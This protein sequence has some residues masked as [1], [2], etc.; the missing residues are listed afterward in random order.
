MLTKTAA[1]RNQAGGDQRPGA[2][3]RRAAS[4]RSAAFIL[5]EPFLPQYVAETKISATLASN[6]YGLPVRMSV[7]S[8]Y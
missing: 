3:L 6:E 8:R 1:T 7:K 2:L 4:I 5:C